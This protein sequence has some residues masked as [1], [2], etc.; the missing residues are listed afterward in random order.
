MW[1]G[2]LTSDRMEPGFEQL[3]PL[4]CGADQDGDL[5]ARV[6]IQTGAGERYVIRVSAQGDATGGTLHLAVTA[7]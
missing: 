4:A 5:R 6:V 7:G 2:A 3:A 1:T